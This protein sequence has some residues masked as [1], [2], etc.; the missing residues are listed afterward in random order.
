ML[1]RSGGALNIEML[2]VAH[3]VKRYRS[4]LNVADT[5]RGCGAERVTVT[6]LYIYLQ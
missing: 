5:Q 3:S 4:G 6:M 2:E 1:H